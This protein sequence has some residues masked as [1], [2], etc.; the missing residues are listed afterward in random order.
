MTEH[1]HSECAAITTTAAEDSTSIAGAGASASSRS[2]L[3]HGTES[4]LSDWEREIL[5]KL[6]TIVWF[7][8]AGQHFRIAHA[9]PQGDMFESP[10]HGPVE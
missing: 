8:W 10:V 6:P 4:L 3:A 9:T 1:A 2:P 7:K 5:R